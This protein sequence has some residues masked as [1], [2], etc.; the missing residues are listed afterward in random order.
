MCH[1]TLPPLKSFRHHLR[2]EVVGNKV[3]PHTKSIVYSTISVF[4]FSSIFLSFCLS[5]CLSACLPIYGDTKI[6][7]IRTS[8]AVLSSTSGSWR[9]A[10]RRS[11]P[12]RRRC[13]RRCT[14][15]G[16]RRSCCTP[17]WTT[18]SRQSE[19]ESERAS[20]TRSPSPP[21][22]P[23]P[24]LPLPLPLPFAPPCPPPPHT[25]TTPHTYTQ[26]LFLSL[27]LSVFSHSVAR[28]LS[29]LSLLYL[30]PSLSRFLP[31]AGS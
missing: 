27:C 23:S 9:R 30:P 18:A 31:L 12:W 6:N 2:E 16:C 26:D 28:S 24:C 15:S 3:V 13:A 19:S 14:S 29:A 20:E 25:H 22:S 11:T 21:L 8:I 10:S 1:F 7:H 17:S 5:V 4:L